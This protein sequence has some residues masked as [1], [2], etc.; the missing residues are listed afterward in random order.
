VLCALLVGGDRN[1][2]TGGD[3]PL[4]SFSFKDSSPV[5]TLDD[6]TWSPDMLEVSLLASRE[7]VVSGESWL[8]CLVSS[9]VS[10]P[11]VRPRWRVAAGR[12]SYERR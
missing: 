3:S 11:L 2:L 9:L 1:Q 10:I 6:G 5:T 4:L 12:R 8:V 7:V